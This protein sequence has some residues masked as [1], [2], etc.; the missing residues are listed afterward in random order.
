MSVDDY[1]RHQAGVISRA[2]ALR[3]GLSTSTIHRRIAEREWARLFPSVYLSRSYSLSSHGRIWAAWLAVPG[4]TVSGATAAF[5]WD[6]HQIGPGDVELTVARDRTVAQQNGIRIYRRDLDPA[7]VTVHRG[8]RV[9]GRALSALH[10]AVALGRS[11]PQMLDRALQ[12]SLAL[13]EL[14]A[15]YYR[16]IGSRRSAAAHS[17]LLA[18]GDRASAES[19]RRL[20]TLVRRAGITGWTVNDPIALPDGTTTPGDLVF[21]ERRVLVEVDGWAWHHTPDRF[22]RDRYRQNQLVA[23]GWTVL[24]FTWSDL[25]QRP[26]Y[27]VGQIRR[28]LVAA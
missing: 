16:Q 23:T 11:G 17:L 12:K 2:Q 10:G 20:I 14:R 28:S 9:T 13:D 24:R 21:R 4:S 22:Q 5:W 7:D 26:D 25:T 3:S 18:A 15:A 1:F 6:L 8:V 27:V 19:E